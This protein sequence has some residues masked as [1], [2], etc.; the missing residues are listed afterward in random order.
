[1]ATHKHYRALFGSVVPSLSKF[2]RF[3]LDYYGP[4]HF[5]LWIFFADLYHISRLLP[6][7][8]LQEPKSQ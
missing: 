6:P 5:G 7:F 1:M 4:R 3:N 2:V 8:F